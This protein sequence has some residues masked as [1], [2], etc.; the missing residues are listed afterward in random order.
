M[1]PVA[2]VIIPA[3]NEANL[4]GGLLRELTGTGADGALQIVVVCNGCTDN[5]AQLARG[6]NGVRVVELAESSKIAALNAG[7]AEATVFPRIYLDADIGISYPAVLAMAAALNAGA[8][9]AAPLPQVDLTGTRWPVRAYYSVWSEL[10]YVRR[11]ALGS[12][13]Y[14]LSAQGRS[15]FGPF[16]DLIADDAYVYCQFAEAERV[17]PPGAVFSIRAPRTVR[18]LTRRRIRIVAGNVELATETGH[19]MQPPGPGW[20]AVVQNKP[21]LLP[22]LPVFLGVNV[23]GAL[24]ARRRAAAGTRGSWGQD[25]TSR[26]IP[27]DESAPVA[28]THHGQG[29]NMPRR[30]VGGGRLSTKPG[31]AKRAVRRLTNTGTWIHFAKLVNFF[32]Y[33]GVGGNALRV[34]AGAQVAPNVSIRNA[35]R[36][37]IGAGA[38]VGQGSF[39]WAGDK[40]GRIELG[41]HALLAP[42]VFLT[43]SNYDFDAGDGPVMDLPRVE[44]DIRIGANTWLGANVV[45]VAGVTIGDG[46]IVAAGAV[47]TRDLPPGVVAGGVPAKV[48]R[49]RGTTAPSSDPADTGDAGAAVDTNTAP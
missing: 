49:A 46:T 38:H 7:D 22:A 48:I 15:R 18:S 27:S 20:R 4:L 13:V 17:N 24:L 14:G 43:A 10:G 3:H 40:H 5:T 26:A 39:L 47:V 37:S 42:N 25:L 21:S 11:H 23:V 41:D 35:E 45:V 6:F 33:D 1:A 32:G 44:A 34:G 9:A 31:A 16:P 36:I 28:Q 29:E 30:A 2:S 19:R 12:G 8:L